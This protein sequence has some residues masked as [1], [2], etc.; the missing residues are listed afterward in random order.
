VVIE[1]SNADDRA[2]ALATF[3]VAGYA[4]LSLAVLGLGIALPG[5][6]CSW[7]RREV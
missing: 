5:P 3:F 1:T 4:A 6:G 7:A 2:G